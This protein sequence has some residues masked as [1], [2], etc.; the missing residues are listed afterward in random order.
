MTVEHLQVLLDHSKDAKQSVSSGRARLLNV[1]EV[2]V[3]VRNTV[4]VGPLDCLMQKPDGRVLLMV[5]GK[6]ARRLLA[7]TMY[8]PVCSRML[9]GPRHQCRAPSA[10]C[11]ARLLNALRMQVTR[12]TCLNA[13]PDQ[14]S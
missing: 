9:S 12:T 2:P 1:A 7:M 13:W 6:I 8:R 3:S 4:R 10:Q 5:A 11:R 14:C